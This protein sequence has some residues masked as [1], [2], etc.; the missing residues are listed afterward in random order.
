MFTLGT[1]TSFL[2]S[3]GRPFALPVVAVAA[4][5][6]CDD[7]GLIAVPA[8]AGLRD[9]GDAGATDAGQASGVD[10][11]FSDAGVVDG[12]VVDAGP[13]LPSCDFEFETIT[14][15]CEGDE[16]FCAPEPNI[17]CA[18]YDALAMWSRREGDDL[19]VQVLFSGRALACRGDIDIG[20]QCPDGPRGQ[21]WYG[22]G[23]RAYVDF[24][25][26]AFAPNAAFGPNVVYLLPAMNH[27]INPQR[28]LAVFPLE[29]ANSGHLLQVAVP[30]SYLS[31]DAN[32]VSVFLEVTPSGCG[33]PGSRSEGD[34]G[35]PSRGGR[36]DDEGDLRPAEVQCI[37]P[38]DTLC[39]R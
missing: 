18:A 15:T 35:G 30:T 39:F 24:V 9:A 2:L 27:S 14:H 11:G 19:L 1:T 26:A 38:E 20:F 31:C 23:D 33:G 8:D 3:R 12:G 37:V 5:V 7:A 22:Q 32:D 10:A 6:A 17:V 34:F 13:E 28:D 36:I 21:P 4:L 25:A 29:V 16:D